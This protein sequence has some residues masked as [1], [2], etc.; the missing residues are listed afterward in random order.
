MNVRV[1]YI[2]NGF[3]SSTII[4][5]VKSEEGAIETLLETLKPD[6]HKEIEILGTEVLEEDYLPF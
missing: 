3:N 1:K 4:T 2:S 5:N 6:F